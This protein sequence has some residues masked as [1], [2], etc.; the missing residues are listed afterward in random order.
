MVERL[1]ARDGDKC[2]LCARPL[3]MTATKQSRR[4]S[5]EH[6]HPR[7]LGGGDEAANL[8]LCHHHCNLHLRDRTL[9]TKLKMQTKWHRETERVLKK[10]RK[11][12]AKQPPTPAAV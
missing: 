1:R 9:E 7:S 12:K 2:W 11:R 5:I 4:I 8:V 3:K 6:L 10:A